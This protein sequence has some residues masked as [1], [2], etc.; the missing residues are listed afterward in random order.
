MPVLRWQAAEEARS[1]EVSDL[2]LALKAA[3]AAAEAHKLQA[4]C[5][6]ALVVEHGCQAML[7]TAATPRHTSVLLAL[8]A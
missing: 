5:G 1:A 7:Q 6:M 2:E 3:Q 4:S 8:N